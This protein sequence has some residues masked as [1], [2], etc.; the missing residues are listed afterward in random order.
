VSAQSRGGFTRPL[1]D[2]GGGVAGGTLHVHCEEMAA[3]AAN[4]TVRFRPTG[5]GLDKKAGRNFK[6]WLYFSGS[7]S[8]NFQTL[9]S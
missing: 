3:E 6:W 8:P 7:L 5:R 4:L 9:W 2:P 1:T